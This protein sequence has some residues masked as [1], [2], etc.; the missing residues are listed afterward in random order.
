MAPLLT[1]GNE[2]AVPAEGGVFAGGGVAAEQRLRFVREKALRA[3]HWR[4]LHSHNAGPAHT[5]I[6]GSGRGLERPVDGT[7]ALAYIHC[8]HQLVD[9]QLWERTE[10]KR[11]NIN[12][13]L[14]LNPSS[15]LS[16]FL[17]FFSL[18]AFPGFILSN[19]R[20]STI[21]RFGDIHLFLTSFTPSSGFSTLHL[22]NHSYRDA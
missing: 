21:V 13:S 3:V 5:S 15:A 22:A 8:S 18:S 11:E 10:R 14:M 12:A 17:S 7:E 4:L 20:S 2:G 16:F 19:F 6:T 9:V 1:F